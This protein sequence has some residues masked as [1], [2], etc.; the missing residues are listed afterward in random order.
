[1]KPL[2]AKGGKKREGKSGGKWEGKRYPRVNIITRMWDLIKYVL[3]SFIVL[4]P[5][6]TIVLTRVVSHLARSDT[7]NITLVVSHLARS[8]TPNIT[9]VVCRAWPAVT[10]P[11]LLELCPAW[12]QWHPRRYLSC[13]AP[14]PQWHPQHYVSCVPP[15]PQW[16][17][18]HYLSCVALC[19]QWHPQHYLSFVPPGPQLHPQHYLSRDA[20]GAKSNPPPPPPSAQCS[21]LAYSYIQQSR[22]SVKSTNAKNTKKSPIHENA[23]ANITCDF[24]NG[25]ISRSRSRLPRTRPATS[26][27]PL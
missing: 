7:P 27:A 17:P 4:K 26:L 6:Y 12:P 20:M 15:G 14:G 24:G 8:D 16:H 18:Q 11:T 13:V 21:L 22:R 23:D 9:W 2:C 5:L 25:D 3:L 10:P 19:P 1:M